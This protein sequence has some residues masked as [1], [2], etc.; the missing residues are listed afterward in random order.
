MQ[1]IP[2]GSCHADPMLYPL[3]FPHG[4]SGWHFNVMQEGNRNNQVRSRNT[5]REFVCYRM[6][7]RYTGN[8]DTDHEGISL[9]MVVVFYNFYVQS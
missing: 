3:F 5:I 8:N 6:A 4:E 9:Y 1:T 2:A 7:I